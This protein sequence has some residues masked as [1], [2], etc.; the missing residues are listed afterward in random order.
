MIIQDSGALIVFAVPTA[1]L[2][3]AGAI[4][5]LHD[6]VP[7]LSRSVDVVLGGAP[8]PAAVL[9]ID[10]SEIDWDFPTR[11]GLA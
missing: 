3:G 10:L 8:A 11:T 1:A 6:H 7:A 4:G 2:A 5:W 9:D